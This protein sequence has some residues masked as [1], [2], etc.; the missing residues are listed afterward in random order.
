MS[1]V[2]GVAKRKKA[3]MTA[4]T[5][6]TTT[7]VNG[8]KRHPGNQGGFFGTRYQFL[9][10]HLEEFHKAADDGV[11]AEFFDKYIPL[12]WEMFPWRLARNEEPVEGAEY[13]TTDD[14]DFAKKKVVME[15]IDPVRKMAVRFETRH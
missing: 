9:N 6:K 4:S 1:K 13:P 2:P 3:P 5:T 11:T 15:D 8:E 7:C 10:S 14:E 12:Y